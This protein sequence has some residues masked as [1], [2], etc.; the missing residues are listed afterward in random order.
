MGRILHALFAASMLAVTAGSAH[1]ATLKVAT[2]APEGS[3]WMR[4]MRAGAATIKE[5]T[6]GRVEMKFYPAGVMGNDAAVLRKI[7]LGQLQGAAFSGAEASLI[8]K[9]A[10]VYSLPFVF[11]SQAEV[12]YVREKVDPLLRQGLAE[13]GYVVAGLSGGGFVYLMSTKDI[14][15]REDLRAAKVWIPP[16][17]KIAQ[18]AYE[19]GGV[20]PIGLPMTDVYPGLQT[21]LIDTVANTTSGAIFF[22]WHTKVKHMVDLPLTY[23]AGL[24]VFDDK[25]LKR[26][27]AADRAVVLAE[28]ES[29]FGRIDANARAENEKARATLERQGVKLFKPSQSETQFWRDIGVEARKRL[30][31]EGELSQTI[32]DAVLAAIAEFRSRQGAAQ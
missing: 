5:R 14:R 24:L 30:I 29:A 10:P 32:V 23:V 4:E 7:K 22:Q 1:A 2:L 15:T 26:V 20:S 6:E 13:H 16:S 17:D 27:E 25:A 12:D 28:I 9:D 11:E 3:G 8:W 18:F 19:A 21:G 31:A